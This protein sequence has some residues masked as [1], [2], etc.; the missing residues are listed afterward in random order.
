M[1]FPVIQLDLCYYNILK[2]QGPLNMKQSLCLF[3]FWSCLFLMEDG[4]C[5]AVPLYL[6]KGNLH[7]FILRMPWRYQS[8]SDCLWWIRRLFFK[9][10]T[11]ARLLFYAGKMDVVGRDR[12]LGFSI[13]GISVWTGLALSC[14]TKC[15]RV[16][17]L[18][19]WFHISLVKEL[20]GLYFVIPL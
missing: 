15:P 1:S 11:I 6:K 12:L 19:F 4:G 20:Q 16:F 14:Y 2:C 17:S 5:G 8:R 13:G 7:P 18:I 3:M 9:L 10:H